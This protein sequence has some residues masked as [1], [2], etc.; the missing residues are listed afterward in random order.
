[1]LQR[2][3]DQCRLSAPDVEVAIDLALGA[4]YFRHLITHSPIDD[5]F[6]TNIVDSLVTVEAVGPTTS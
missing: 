1:M 2:A 3:A 6:I 5:E 4:V